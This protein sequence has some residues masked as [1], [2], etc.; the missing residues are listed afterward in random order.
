MRLRAPLSGKGAAVSLFLCSVAL[1]LSRQCFKIL[2]VQLSLGVSLFQ[3][4]SAF[5]RF[6]FFHYS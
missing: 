6:Y 1:S 4:T 3:D 5:L 2:S